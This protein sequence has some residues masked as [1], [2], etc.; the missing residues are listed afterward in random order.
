MT[1]TAIYEFVRHE[2]GKLVDTKD[3]GPEPYVVNIET[4]TTENDKFRVA[5]WTGKHMQLTLMSIPVGGEIGLEKHATIDQ[6][7]R[8]EAGEA[9]VVMGR[10]KENLDQTF[11]ARDDFIV[12]VPAGWWHNVLNVGETPLKVYSLYAPPEHDHGT[13]HETKK[14]SDEAHH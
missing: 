7:L 9:K 3:Y 10:E 4:I 6:F 5:K 13:I 11:E 8:L 2:R 12:L 14:E 1:P